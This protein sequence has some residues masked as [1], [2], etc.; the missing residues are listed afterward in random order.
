M[1]DTTGYGTTAVGDSVTNFKAAGANVVYQAQIDAT[2]PDVT[3][4]ML[5]AK[6]AGAKA[7]VVWSV[8]TG[9]LARLMNTRAQLQ[10]D[11]P[12]VGHPSLGSGEV[13]QLLDKPENWDKV[14]MIGYRSCSF[15]PAGKLP[16]R[17]AEL[18]TRLSA[19]KI[20]TA[21]TSLW[22]VCGGY[23]AVHMV[24]RAVE[25]AKSSDPEAIIAHWNSLNPY[26]G[27]FGSYTYNPKEH[28]GYPT[29]DVVMSVA[30]SSRDGAFSLAPGYV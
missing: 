21:D 2:Q 16:P 14:Y 17:T 13:K 27:I 30:N 15:D 28:N 5:R 1:G 11:I 4:D 7:I 19:A 26:P 23:D 24:T 18:V 29:D 10:W 6:N 8:T 3:A 12:I 22:W 9:F 20:A 25:A